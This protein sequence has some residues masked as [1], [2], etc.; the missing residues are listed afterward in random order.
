MI[1]QEI[2]SVMHYILD[3]AEGAKPYYHNIPEDFTVP[4]VF[5]PQP[6]ISSRG[7]TLHNYALEFSWFIKFFHE[8]E[9]QAYNMGFTALTSLQ[10]GRNIVPLINHAGEPV[11]KGFRLNDPR[12]RVIAD[13][14]A[15]LFLSWDSCRPY[16]E[17]ETQKMMRYHANLFVKTAFEN[18]VRQNGG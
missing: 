16:D 6:E 7:D 15:Q 9:Q 10:S 1:D 17:P 2:A 13:G 14:T 12:L 18:A 4:A 3:C 8:T 5:F 11:G